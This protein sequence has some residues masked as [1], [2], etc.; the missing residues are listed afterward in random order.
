MNRRPHN[1][2]RAHDTTTL[3]GPPLTASV[4]E[5]NRRCA[6]I[7]QDGLLIDLV[8]KYV[9]YILILMLL[10]L[11][12]Y[13]S[14]DTNNFFSRTPWKRVIK[15]W[16][17]PPESGNYKN[18]FIMDCCPYR[19][20][21]PHHLEWPRWQ[22]SPWTVQVK[23]EASPWPVRKTTKCHQDRSGRPPSVIMTG[24]DYDQVSPWPVRMT[25]KCHFPQ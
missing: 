12:C 16:I 18:V 20:N 7:Y 22:L 4:G 17:S 25:T 9:R 6:F 15:C 13:F 2:W 24:Q 8:I 14:F 10:S 5:N 21:K 3:W 19:T 11:L 23:D 1:V